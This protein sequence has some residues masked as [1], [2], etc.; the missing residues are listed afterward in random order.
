MGE[1]LTKQELESKK[2]FHKKRVKFYDAK[3]K[4]IENKERRIGFRWYD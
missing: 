3:I 1:K 4:N 2:K